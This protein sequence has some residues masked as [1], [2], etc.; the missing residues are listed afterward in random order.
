MEGDTWGISGPAFIAGFAAAG[1]VLFVVTLALRFLLRRGR[2]ASRELHPY[3][4]AYLI[5]GAS[6]ATAAA[7]AG[8][9]LMGLIASPARGR[10]ALAPAAPAVRAPLDN[11]LDDALVAALRRKGSARV[12]TVPAVPEVR[13]VLDGLA[14]G[15]ER[16]GYALGSRERSALRWTV[17]PLLTLFAIGVARLVA[18]LSNDRPV[19]FLVIAL[20]VLAVVVLGLLLAPTP[21]ASGAG[22]RA[23]RDARRRGESLNPAMSPAWATYGPSGAA[24]GVALYGGL[25]LSSIDPDFAT[26]AEIQRNLAVGDSGGSSSYYGGGTSSCGGGGGGCG[27]GGGGGCGG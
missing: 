17:L 10:V 23:L 24:L 13:Q 21:R 16:D 9:R 12:N 14:A 5:G 11:P 6:R 8:L 4:I 25:A 18:G 19:L 3:E 7:L 20:V 26:Q 1:A 2:S 15:L 27:G 22:R